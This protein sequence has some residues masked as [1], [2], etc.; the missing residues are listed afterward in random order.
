M[1][2]SRQAT[3]ASWES[4]YSKASLVAEH[5]QR[6]ANFDLLKRQCVESGWKG[7]YSPAA[8]SE[9]GGT[10]AGVFAVAR[11]H[12][13]PVD[14]ILGQHPRWNSVFIRRKGFDLLMLVAYFKDGGLYQ[15]ENFELMRELVAVVR[16]VVCPWLLAAD[17]NV[18]PQVLFES[19]F[20]RRLQGCIVPAGKPTIA[21][22]NELDYLIVSKS[23]QGSVE[24]TVDHTVPFRPH[25]A[26]HV[27]LKGGLQQVRLPSLN[28]ID[29][30]P[31]SFGPRRAWEHFATTDG[32]F[33]ILGCVAKTREQQAIS[34]EF[35]PW[36]RQAEGYLLDVAVEP[37]AKGRGTVLEYGSRP[38]VESNLAHAKWDSSD[39][40]YWCGLQRLVDDLTLP[41]RPAAA[42]L[43][44]QLP[45]C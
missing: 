34:E 19:G 37:V 36:T 38:Q 30:V 22:G 40:N 31:P 41:G 17:F 2:I 44:R 27:S 11:R 7:S 12:L 14:E 29:P 4:C 3:K 35:S 16:S 33:K 45:A 39:L 8:L 15:D 25:F 24:V 42:R 26:L 23:L 20:A 10:R 13:N 6:G 1:N 43:K 5:H 9:A 32:S 21:S 18:A 28:N